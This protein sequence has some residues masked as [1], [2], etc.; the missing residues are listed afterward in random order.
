LNLQVHLDL[1]FKPDS[2]AKMSRPIELLGSH[3]TD[4]NTLP[5]PSGEGK[6]MINFTDK[7][8]ERKRND[9]HRTEIVGRRVSGMRRAQDRSTSNGD[10][11]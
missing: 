6:K 4:S 8:K 9:R 2:W 1:K 11:I 3:N 7:Q 10:Q 5:P